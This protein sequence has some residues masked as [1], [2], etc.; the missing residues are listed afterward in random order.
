MSNK[1]LVVINH[2]DSVQLFTKIEEAHCAVMSLVQEIFEQLPDT[3]D[4]KQWSAKLEL[5]QQ[6]EQ[7]AY[8]AS[9]KL[10]NQN[11]T[12]HTTIIVINE[13]LA[14]MMR[15]LEVLENQIGTGRPDRNRGRRREHEHNNHLT[16]EFNRVIQQSVRR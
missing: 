12:M 13:Q 10:I 14:S 8:E 15:R 4:G 9:L 2:P 16:A 6:E 3:S 1:N 11:N 5:V 7:E